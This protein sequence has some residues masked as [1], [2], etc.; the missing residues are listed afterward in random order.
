MTLTF[1]DD[2][3]PPDLSVSVREMQLFMKRLRKAVGHT[4][5]RFFGCGEYG[6]R[7]Q[8]PHYHVLLFG[9]APNDQVPWRRTSTG[10]VVY[11]SA[12]LE[13]VWPF[14]HVEVGTVT[15]QSAGYVARY[16]TKKVSGDAA[17]LHY[18]R[19]D[20]ATGETWNVRPEFICMSTRPGIGS[21]WFEKYCEDAFPSDFVVI[22]G[23]KRSVP[24]YYKKKLDEFEQ[25][26]VSEAR[27]K[28]ALAHADNNTPE[29][30]AVREE[31]AEIR[32][33]RLQREM[34]TE[35]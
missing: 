11:R 14:G 13:K 1:S 2:H 3:L 21:L 8:R 28:R 24:R 7:N 34:E 16:V 9:W 23:V 22:D 27:Q 17:K 31:L 30:L 35:T 4:R 29:R 5:I 20:E 15:L 18:A 33:Q 10:H 19:V 6:D 32:L 25:W 26:E 12:F